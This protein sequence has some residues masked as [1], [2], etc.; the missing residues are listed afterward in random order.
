MCCRLLLTFNEIIFLGSI[1]LI[2]YYNYWLIALIKIEP[3]HTKQLLYIMA[4]CWEPYCHKWGFENYV[5]VIQPQ[6]LVWRKCHYQELGYI[7]FKCYQLSSEYHDA[8]FS[9]CNWNNTTRPMWQYCS[10]ENIIFQDSYRCTSRLTC[11]RL[12]SLHHNRILCHM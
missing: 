4:Q 3:S 5:M 11:S 2:F 6:H 8:L 1:F 10:S 7:T 9:Q 12:W